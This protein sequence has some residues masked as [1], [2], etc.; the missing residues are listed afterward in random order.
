MLIIN[1]D[2]IDRYYEALLA[3]DASFLGVFLVGVKTTGV[4]CLPTCRARKPLRKNVVFYSTLE[5]VQK[6][7]FRACKVCRPTEA[8]TPIPEDVIRALELLQ[9][10]PDS[11]VTDAVL[12]ESGLQPASIRRW[13]KRHHGLTFHAFQRHYRILKA[14]QQLQTG[15][16][17]TD[18]AFGSGYESL[19]GFTA[20]FKR[21]TGKR[22]SDC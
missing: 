8:T 19:S 12:V 1:P 14:E 13:F 4:F 16:R 21:V 7:G 11:K 3:Q 17:V 20:A 18:A 10:R 15:E 2:L 9:A 6:D 5:D 22:P